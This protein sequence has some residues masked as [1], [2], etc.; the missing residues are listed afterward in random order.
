MVEPSAKRVYSRPIL[1]DRV[2]LVGVLAG[3]GSVNGVSPQ[4]R[5]SAK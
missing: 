4:N 5:P 3:P 2:E 1:V